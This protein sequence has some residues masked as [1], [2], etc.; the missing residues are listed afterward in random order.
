MSNADISLVQTLYAAFGRGDIATITAAVTSDAVWE[1]NG[2]RQDHPI[3]GKRVGPAQVADFF[4]ALAETL[5]FQTFTPQEFHAVDGKVFV[6]GHYSFTARKTG[7]AGQSRW[8]HVFT[9]RNGKVTAFLDFLDT[10][11][12]VETSR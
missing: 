4:R 5:D 2:R 11:Q 10:A 1:L 3:L 6:L 8:M 12:L 9:I 7:R